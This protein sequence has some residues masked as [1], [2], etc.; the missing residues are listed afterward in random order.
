MKHAINFGT[1]SGPLH[2]PHFLGY[3]DYTP[4]KTYDIIIPKELQLKEG[5]AITMDT[6]TKYKKDIIISKIVKRR[7]AKGDWSEQKVHKTPDFVRFIAS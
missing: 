1:T 3:P 7:P 2:I 5:D 4:P 6:E